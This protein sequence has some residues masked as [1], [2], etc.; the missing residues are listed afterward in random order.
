[1]QTAPLLVLLPLVPFE[2]ESPPLSRPEIAFDCSF[3]SS[4]FASASPPL[5]DASP[6]SELASAPS[7]IASEGPLT[8]PVAVPPEPPFVVV[9]WVLLAVF[10]WWHWSE[11][12]VSPVACW[13]QTAPLLV[14]LPLVPFECESPPLS[15]PEI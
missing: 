8:P 4:T 15:R 9:V 2:C 3:S 6:P 5:A 1:M 13:T 14:P 7:P 11:P 12:A 10:S